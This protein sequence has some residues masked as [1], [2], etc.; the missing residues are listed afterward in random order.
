VKL[1]ACNIDL[2][3]KIHSSVSF[4]NAVAENLRTVINSHVFANS[5]ECD[6]QLFVNSHT[7]EIE[8]TEQTAAPLIPS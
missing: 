7:L 3:V 6:G 8:I 2:D 4:N 5:V 1:S